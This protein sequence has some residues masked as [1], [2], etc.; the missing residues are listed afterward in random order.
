[1]KKSL[2][3]FRLTMFAPALCTCVCLLAMTAAAQQPENGTTDERPRASNPIASDEGQAVARRAIASVDAQR[4][5]YAQLRQRINM[6]GQQLV[7]NGI[8]Q[9]MGE[10]EE[11]RLRLDL[12]VNV[13]EQITS[14]QQ[15]CNGRFLYIRRDL[16]TSSSL[17]RVD[18]RRIQEAVNRSNETDGNLP[19]SQ[20]WMLLGGL[21]QLLGRLEKN[22]QFTAPQQATLENTNVT[23]IDGF[24]KPQALLALLPQHQGEIESGK[25]IDAKA[26]NPQLPTQ[27]RMVVRRDDGFPLRIEY[28][29]SGKAVEPDQPPPLTPIMAMELFDIRLGQ[30]IDPLTF[31]YK[32]GN[33]EVADHTEVYLNSLGLRG[34]RQAEATERPAPRR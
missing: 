26:L 24:W 27:I 5:V 22:F 23:V 34:P 14:M 15:V 10:G 7:G 21:P 16:G 17:G 30:P 4:S 12:K 25:P 31:V 33:Q 29:R 11:R 2:P 28:L 18:L 13:G 9:Q 3:T 6:F 19:G 20:Q 8:Y 32:P 1:M